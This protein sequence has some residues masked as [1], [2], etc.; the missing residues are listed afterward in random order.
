[1]CTSFSK[2]SDHAIWELIRELLQKGLN[3]EAVKETPPRTP[4]P[5]ADAVLDLGASHAIFVENDT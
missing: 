3:G 4:L 1:M 5:R 2:F